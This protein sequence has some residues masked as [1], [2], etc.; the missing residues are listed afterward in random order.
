MTPAPETAGPEAFYQAIA[1]FSDFD[2]FT[3][4]RHFH[5]VPAGWWVLLTDVKGSTAAIEAGRYK[6]VNRVGVAAIVCAQ[7][8]MDG[9]DFPYVFG[10]DGAT[11]LVPASRLAAVSAELAA[12][13]DLSLERFGLALRVGAVSVAQVEA[14]GGAIEVARYEV[15]GGRSIALF[16][17]GGLALAEKLIKGD[18]AAF[19]VAAAPEG[20]VPNLDELSCR[21][22]AVP[23]SRGRAVSLMVVA[24]TQ[25]S[26]ATYQHALEAI[27]RAVD[28][29]LE[30]ANPIQRSSMSYRGWWECVRDEVRQFPSP[31]SR[32]FASKVLGITVA[33]LSFRYKLRPFFFDPIAYA[34]SIPAHCDYRKFDDTLRMTIDC[35]PGQVPGLREELEAMRGRGEIYYGLHEARQSLITCYVRSTAPGEHIHFVDGGDGGYAMAAKQ[36]KA[37][38]KA[39]QA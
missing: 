9:V 5:R 26:A 16:R 29:G 24:R 33:V 38:M 37:Q 31:W 30:A 27:G 10:G 11:L 25:D 15:A 22:N 36:M 21:W 6:D 14:A 7:R 2:Q 4:P 18:E 1:P 13:R 8:G 3:D 35:E 17:G 39:G 34:S 12:L 20:L 19:S 32:A 28:H 23:A